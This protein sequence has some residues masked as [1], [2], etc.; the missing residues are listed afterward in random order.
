MIGATARA[1]V[2]PLELP[3]LINPTLLERDRDIEDNASRAKLQWNVDEIQHLP[4]SSLLQLKTFCQHGESF[5]LWETPRKWSPIET[6]AQLNARLPALIVHFLPKRHQK[7]FR[8]SQ[9]K[10]SFRIPGV[11][12]EQAGSSP[13]H[14]LLARAVEHVTRLLLLMRL[15]PSG[16]HKKGKN[17]PADPS[18]I[19][20][21][22]NRTLPRLIAYGLARRL[23][24][25]DPFNATDS[26][27]FAYVKASDY[28]KESTSE[29]RRLGREITRMRIWADRGLWSDVAPLKT[30]PGKTTSVKGEQE[31]PTEPPESNPHLPLPDEYVGQMGM[32]ARWII[33]ELGPAL[34]DLCTQIEALWQRTERADATDSAIS[35]VRD[36]ALRVLL[37]GAIW[38]DSKGNQIEQLPFTEMPRGKP[39]DRW[40]ARTLKDVLYLMKLLQAAH[41]FVAG[42]SMAGRN[43]EVTTLQRDC[44]QDVP[45]ASPGVSGRTWKLVDRHDGAVRE[46]VLPDLAMAAVEQQVRLV[47]AAERM[48]RLTYRARKDGHEGQHLWAQIGVSA[49]DARKQVLKLNSHMRWFARTL[50][51]STQPLGQSLRIHRFRKTIARLAALAIVEAPKV[52]MQVFGHRN[53]NDTLYYILADKSLQADIEMVARELR[54]MRARE[55]V[56]A[57]ADAEDRGESAGFGGPAGALISKAIAVHREHLHRTGRTWG[58]DS[59]YEI[60]DILTLRGIAFQVVRPGVVCTKYPETESGPCNKSFGKPEPA[61]CQTHCQHRLEEPLARLDAEASIQSCVTNYKKAAEEDNDLTKGAWA[62]QVVVHLPRFP[63]LKAKWEVD[64]LMREMLER[65]REEGATLA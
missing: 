65:A 51:M 22:A 46:W 13:A 39:A 45:G 52:L 64:P 10:S 30:T 38:V 50:G 23:D 49:A 26:R 2:V 34:L 63:D 19:V 1:S 17:R 4:A 16:Y 33:E 9:V 43:S 24:G 40:P 5:E 58:A 12:L 53:L 41:Y 56:K 14:Q 20:K 61:R 32:H 15:G 42:L 44:V 18:T 60:A 57:I 25:P 27:F 35:Q 47:R 29:A 21:A 11:S 7:L 28:A 54:V 62:V 37:D 31:A 3:R 55:T 36:D 59:V 6:K 48:G 8:G